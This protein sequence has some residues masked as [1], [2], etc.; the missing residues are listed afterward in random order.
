[1]KTLLC[2]TAAIALLA[3]TS[4]SVQAHTT[5]F[6]FIPQ[7]NG[8]VE[9]YIGTYSHAGVPPQQGSLVISGVGSFAFD[10]LHLGTSA[11]ALGLTAPNATY[12]EYTGLG[13]NVDFQSVTVS[14]LSSGS[15]S[16]DISG[17]SNVHWVETSNF[18]LPIS[19]TVS[20]SS[21][22]PEPSSLALLGMGVA[23]LAA[24][25]RRRRK[26]N[27]ESDNEA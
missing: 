23:G 26:Q 14:G 13:A 9:F 16:F 22:V 11:A 5:A 10:G 20:V 2:T 1:M 17:M 19:A 18:P 25:R 24:A 12:S 7:A 8:D 3:V 6:G 4:Q 27:E 15:Y 21:V